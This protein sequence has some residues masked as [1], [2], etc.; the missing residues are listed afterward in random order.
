M[1]IIKFK[2]YNLKIYNFCNCQHSTQQANINT[3][4][5]SHF[6]EYFSLYFKLKK[7]LYMIDSVKLFKWINNDITNSNTLTKII[8]KMMNEDTFFISFDDSKNIYHYAYFIFENSLKIKK[9]NKYTSHIINFII[10]QTKKI[11][12]MHINN[13]MILYKI[14]KFEFNIYENESSIK[15]NDLSY[16]IGILKN[17]SNLLNLNSFD[18]FNKLKCIHDIYNYIDMKG[19]NFI[20]HL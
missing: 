8:Y 2:S 3:I 18:T 13:K 5:I 17:F 7:V 12:K 14:E 16:I 20:K 9:D 6:D 10:K 19:N 4:R 1:K 15:E 11:L